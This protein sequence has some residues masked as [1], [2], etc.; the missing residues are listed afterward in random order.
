VQEASDA[1]AVNDVAELTA[2]AE[3]AT[4]AR[5]E[6]E[7][8]AE[9]AEARAAE[10]TQAVAD[11]EAMR[12]VDA[13]LEEQH[14]AYE[15]QLERDAA[16]KDAA[17]ARALGEVDR[18]KAAVAAAE[19]VAR[20][21]EDQSAAQRT[22]IAALKQSLAR[23]EALQQLQ[24]GP[25]AGRG[26]VPATRGSL[27]AALL[28]VW[29][30]AV[31]GAPD[32]GTAL[33][34]RQSPWQPP[35]AV[36]ADS[37]AM[38]AL[39]CVVSG[40]AGPGGR[41]GVVRATV[42][43][44]KACA[45]VRSRLSAE[46]TQWEP[47][48]L[49]ASLA[50]SGR[51]GA[52][53]LAYVAALVHAVGPGG[54][55]SGPGASEQQLASA[56]LLGRAGQV[57][58]AVVDLLAS[59]G[60]R[61]VADEATEAAGMDEEVCSAL[62][63]AAEKLE[64]W[65]AAGEDGS[66]ALQDC[67]RGVESAGWQALQSVLPDAGA[68][69]ATS[70]TPRVWAYQLPALKAVGGSV[71]SVLAL[72]G[73]S[74]H[75]GIGAPLT[76]LLWAGMARVR[77][78]DSVASALR[79]LRLE[80]AAGGGS[81][82]GASP[83]SGALVNCLVASITGQL[84]GLLGRAVACWNDWV[85]ERVRN[86]SVPLP[87]ASDAEVEGSVAPADAPRAVANAAAALAEEARP[88]VDAIAACVRVREGW[89]CLPGAAVDQLLRCLSLLSLALRNVDAA[90]WAARVT[91][92][93]SDAAPG[94]S[95]VLS[96]LSAE[97]G[98]LVAELVVQAEPCRGADVPF[99][100]PTVAA[101]S[102]FHVACRS[103]GETVTH[104][105]AAAA[106]VAQLQARAAALSTALALRDRELSEA[107]LRCST[108]DARIAALAPS[109]APDMDNSRAASS[110]GPS[111]PASTGRS[112]AA[113]ATPLKSGSSSAAALASAATPGAHHRGAATGLVAETALLRAALATLQ[114]RQ[115]AQAA[116]GA[117]LTS[118]CA[119]LAQRQ[120]WAG[121]EGWHGVATTSSARAG[122]VLMQT[123][124]G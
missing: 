59:H 24:Q 20:V 107:T 74:L 95:T 49:P 44:A 5:L 78:A 104:G 29:L 11:F 22:H 67:V 60:G 34:T 14:S 23:V 46:A 63:V 119:A 57:L 77:G 113:A 32:E 40:P 114:C 97:A 12:E 93:L 65:L 18:L 106:Q 80:S 17:L 6:A 45:A 30:P 27:A 105:V 69:A 73:A 13:A 48:A 72:H 99:L 37:L 82:G 36:P 51:A 61:P 53:P 64:R 91:L 47:T 118:R 81:D 86:G 50:V 25:S 42:A 75:A 116:T 31:T 33:P 54:A 90:S 15:A 111:Q 83:W 123:G 112:S 101:G 43:C 19:W 89:H 109:A 26:G 117:A 110:A 96:S 10:L 39:R 52:S 121:A 7:G 2:L 8:R 79:S 35:V 124:W 4:T 70:P 38:H 1:A 102:T 58:H 115:A 98:A 62:E 28:R 108:L 85:E 56:A 84:Q 88:I 9:A 55:G 92:R 76:S 3:Q 68:P 66:S 16:E 120:T 87:A 71:D 21:A 100:A 94:A 103:L 122:A 41:V